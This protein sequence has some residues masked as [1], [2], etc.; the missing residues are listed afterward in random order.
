M[1]KRGIPVPTVNNDHDDPHTGNPVVIRKYRDL[2][3][4]LVAKSVLESAGI[5]CFMADDNLVRLD[6]FYS[7]LIG[8]I[9]LLVREEDAEAAI[10]L[11]DESRPEN[12]DVEGVG[13]Y[14]QP[15]CPKC[16]SMDISLDGLDKPTTYAE[17]FVSLPIPLMIKGWK[18]HACG[19]QWNEDDNVQSTNPT[20]AER[21]E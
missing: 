5:E 21:P 19:N 4:A 8:G 11:L 20:S 2:P 1:S 16:G 10:K 18:C 6:W 9:K 14:E 13:E 12:F 17:L 3:E 7:N 15:H